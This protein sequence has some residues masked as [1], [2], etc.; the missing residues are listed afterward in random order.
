MAKKIAIWTAVLCAA[1]VC[2]YQ[3]FASTPQKLTADYIDATM[4]MDYKKLIGCFDPATQS[5]MGGV[6]GLVSSFAGFELTDIMALAPLV[7]E[8]MDYQI[9]SIEVVSY[10]GMEGFEGLSGIPVLYEAAAA[11]LAEEAEVVF[12]V[13]SE[14]TGQTSTCQMTVKKYGMEWLIPGDEDLTYL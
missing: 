14:V 12:T 3:F 1:A 6:S 4:N 2:Y 10:S 8:K 11:F 5:A 13:S 9:D 7:Q